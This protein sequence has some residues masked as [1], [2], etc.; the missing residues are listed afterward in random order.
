MHV[1]RYAE[2]VDLTFPSRSHTFRS[3]TTT[4]AFIPTRGQTTSI[5]RPLGSLLP[6][7]PSS[8]PPFCY[9]HHPHPPNLSEIQSRIFLN[10]PPT[11][12]LHPAGAC[13]IIGTLLLHLLLSLYFLMILSIPA[14][15]K[16]G[17]ILFAANHRTKAS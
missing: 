8:P 9:H 6:C 1:C 12:F 11:R 15:L 16:P 17:R 7:P 10:I 5:E 2:S 3:I 14:F 13:H 4:P